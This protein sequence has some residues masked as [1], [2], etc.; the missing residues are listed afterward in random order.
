MHY[1]VYAGPN[2]IFI[3]KKREVNLREI[4]YIVKNTQWLFVSFIHSHFSMFYLLFPCETVSQKCP[5][6]IH[7]NFKNIAYI[8]SI[9]E[10]KRNK[11]LFHLVVTFFFFS[12]FVLKWISPYAVRRVHSLRM[13]VRWVE[14][15]KQIHFLYVLV[16][17]NLIN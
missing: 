8:S 2:P 1:I 15:K 4:F 10:E 13:L 6:L 16:L 3:N 9:K 17:S 14:K 5:D 7:N 12:F 11:R